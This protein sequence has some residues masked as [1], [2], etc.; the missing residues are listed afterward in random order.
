MDL[1]AV[2]EGLGAELARGAGR[3][4][5]VLRRAPRLQ[6]GIETLPRPPELLP[7]PRAGHP[8]AVVAEPVVGRLELLPEGMGLN[9]PRALLMVVEPDTQGLAES[10]VARRGT[11]A[12]GGV[13]VQQA[14]E[15]LQEIIGQA[16]TDDLRSILGFVE[17]GFPSYVLEHYIL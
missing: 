5:D 12:R 10:G 15:A 17:H 9:E 3:E 6:D 1:R 16:N 4:G 11:S 14:I 2:G 13:P 7:Q 8:V